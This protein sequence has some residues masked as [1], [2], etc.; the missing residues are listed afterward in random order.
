MLLLANNNFF[1]LME[2]FM[3][4]IL[5]TITDEAPSL[6]TASFLPIVKAFTK[7]ANIDIQAKDIS[8]AYRVLSNFSECLTDEQQQYELLNLENIVNDPKVNII[9][10]PNISASLPQLRAIIK[11]LKEKGYNIP[12]YPTNPTTDE[13]FKIIKKYS[14][15]LGSAVNPVLRQGNSDRRVATPVKKYAERNPHSMG[16]WS[17]NSKSHVATMETN[18]FYGNE[19]SHIFP[20]ATQVKII[21]KTANQKIILK[22][23]FDIEKNEILDATK[24]S[25]QEYR[26]F[27]VREFADAKEKNVLASIHLKA[28]MMKISDPILFGHAVEIFFAEL[29]EKHKDVFEKLQIN[30]RNGFSEVLNKIQILP[31]QQK[32][33]I[34]KDIAMIL[35]NNADLAMV[36]SDKGITNLNVPSDV[37]IDASMPAAIRSSGKM[38]NKN[39]NLQDTKYIIPDRAYAG[40]YDA[41]L[42]F[43]RKNGAFDVAT[44]G[45]VSNVG[46]MAK[47]AEEYGSHDKTFE[48]HKDGLV[49]IIDKDNNIILE[50]K[51]QKGDIYRACQTKDIAIKDWVKLAIS[52]ATITKNPAIFWLDKN[53]AHDKN[54]IKKVK[55][56]L[57]DYN[58]SNLEI[59]IL[60]PIEATKYSLQRVKDGKNTISVTGNILR[61]YLT[62]LFPILEL[63]TSAKMLSIVPLL[64]GGAMFETGAGGSAPKHVQQLI[65]ENHLRW[66]SLGEFLALSSSLEELAY[67]TKDNKVEAL[68]NALNKANEEFLAENKSPLRKAGDLDNRGSHFYLAMYWAKALAMQNTDNELK[69]HFKNIYASMQ[70]SEEKILTELNEVQGQKVDLGGYYKPCKNKLEKIMRPSKTF[71]D[72]VDSI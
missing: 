17:N 10:L 38:W 55:E 23:F 18:D 19:K 41:T 30:T 4:K 70:Q 56:Y 48:I 15:I 65:E 57:T 7:Q 68:A 14:K 46:L 51:V 58:I 32:N 66:D 12:D 64:A 33:N 45:D 52:R 9:K 28:T 22:D 69:S 5:Y 20:Q 39:G 11:E 21:L 40:I 31:I 62:D 72:I 53:R 44:M 24:M 42:D 43:C 1:N 2:F 54:I 50:H 26:K 37:I 36:D 6:A 25:I 63:G 35:E 27:L 47:Q 60:S 16:A 29:F 61:D 34:E 13:D 71:N 3:F 49:Q 67:K 59:K 8:L